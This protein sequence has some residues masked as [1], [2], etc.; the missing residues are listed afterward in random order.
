MTAARVDI[1]IALPAYNEERSIA[2]TLAEAQGYFSDRGL[3]YEI[4]VAADGDDRTRETA[5]QIAARD[6]HIRIIG[7]PGRRGKGRG[8]REA[9]A[10]LGGEVVG[11]AD[12]DGKTPFESLDAMRARL[13]E[14]YDI[15]IGS[16]RVA[17]SRVEVPQP[18]YRRAGARGF[19]VARDALLGLQDI[20]DTQ[21]GFKFFRAAAARDL[22]GRQRVDGYMFDAEILYLARQAGYRIAQVPV[23]WRD[24]ADSRV[25]LVA[26]NARSAVDL[27]RI[28][29][30]AGHG[31]PPP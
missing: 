11:F 29:F 22:F 12:A 14:G 18:L 2:R 13:D 4:V 9:M 25:S 30:A 1:G 27:M 8:V 17:G 23:R 31:A 28:R 26:S 19:N 15:A 21:C 3:T 7:G 5:G 16:R 24:D 10:I 20:P 6:P